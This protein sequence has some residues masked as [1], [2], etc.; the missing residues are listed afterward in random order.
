MIILWSVKWC[1]FES[2]TFQLSLVAKMQDYP[3]NGL[4]LVSFFIVGVGW[5]STERVDFHL[6]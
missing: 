5:G 1:L 6:G 2:S 4:M 3:M